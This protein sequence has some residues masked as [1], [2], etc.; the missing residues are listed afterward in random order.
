L[1]HSWWCIVFGSWSSNSKFEFHLFESFPKCSNL[2][3]PKLAILP[4]PAQQQQAAARATLCKASLRKPAAAARRSRAAEL[5]LRP[6]SAAGP[7]SSLRLR[8]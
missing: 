7:F 6:I 1:W 5:A 2:L 3:F 4:N 8:R